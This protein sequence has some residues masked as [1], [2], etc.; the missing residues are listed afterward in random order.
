MTVLPFFKN[1]NVYFVEWPRVLVSAGGP[2]THEFSV[3]VKPVRLVGRNEHRRFFGKFGKFKRFSRGAIDV[4]DF[5][6]KMRI[7]RPNP[8]CRFQ[9]IGHV[10]PNCGRFF[11]RR[12]FVFG[13]ERRSCRRYRRKGENYCEFLHMAVFPFHHIIFWSFIEAVGFL[14]ICF[15][16][17]MF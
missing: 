10:A 14:S 17:C 12:K 13:G 8:F 5:I 1:F 4:C 6:E 11:Y 3:D 2:G 16:F 7:L 9:R 15:F